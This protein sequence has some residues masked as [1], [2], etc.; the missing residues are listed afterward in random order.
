MPSLAKE[1]FKQIK[2]NIQIY[3]IFVGKET[4]SIL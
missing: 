3:H 4:I 1:N 2:N